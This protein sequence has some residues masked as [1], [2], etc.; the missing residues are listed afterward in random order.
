MNYDDPDRQKEVVEWANRQGPGKAKAV[1]RRILELAAKAEEDGQDSGAEWL[2]FFAERASNPR[3]YPLIYLQPW[4]VVTHLHGHSY[5]KKFPSRHSAQEWIDSCKTKY[6]EAKQWIVAICSPQEQPKE[7]VLAPGQLYCPWCGAGRRFKSDGYG[8]LR[9]PV[10]RIPTEN[11]FTHRANFKS[12][13][14]IGE[15]SI[16]SHKD[17]RKRKKESRRRVRHGGI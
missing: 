11:W 13:G 2:R 6:V 5:K 14:K 16:Q 4:A 15:E 10:C 1:A 8:Y 12:A 9:C 7:L 17:M 3:V